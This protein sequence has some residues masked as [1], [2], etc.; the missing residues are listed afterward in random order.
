VGR[1]GEIIRPTDVDRIKIST[2]AAVATLDD[3]EL[4]EVVARGP[5]AIRERATQLRRDKQATHEDGPSTE[6]RDYLESCPVRA[7]LADPAVFD[8]Q[9]LIQ[10]RLRPVLERLGREFP[11]A[12]EEGAWGGPIVAIASTRLDRLM[13]V[14]DAGVGLTF[15]PG[16][17]SGGGWLIDIEGDGDKA[18]DSW[19][20]LLG[21]EVL[22]TL[23]WSSTRR[24]HSLMIVHE[25]RM[26]AI[27]AALGRR[28]VIK[29][30]KGVSNLP[31][32]EICCGGLYKTGTAIQIQSVVPP[33]PR[34]DGVPRQWHDI[35]TLQPVPEAFYAFL[36]ALA[37]AKAAQQA[38]Q[39]V[40]ASQGHADHDPAWDGT[41][42]IVDAERLEHAR[43]WLHKKLTAFARKV[44]SEVKGNRRTALRDHTR[45]LAGILALANN[46]KYHLLDEQDVIDRMTADDD[47]CGLEPERR[48][49]AMTWA[50]ETGKA[51]PC[52]PEEL[53][54]FEDW[55]DH[56]DEGH[57][58][59]G[60]VD[61]DLDDEAY[62]DPAY[63]AVDELD[64]DAD[65][66]P[67]RRPP[68]GDSARRGLPD[69][70]RVGPRRSPPSCGGVGHTTPRRTGPRLES[71]ARNLVLSVPASGRR[72]PET[73]QLL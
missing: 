48:N 61:D 52:W 2:I 60:A 50:L 19:A 35:E 59:L 24:G 47:E 3:A 49:D 30:K 66:L 51:E 46:Q 8:R 25:A 1:P 22:E 32:L 63:D 54:L 36:E 41:L 15:G 37:A 13:L 62:D 29:D 16:R 55:Q 69:P 14:R 23:G 56:D 65:E 10:H 11:V 73:R 70:R 4:A 67:A 5:R 26:L 43:T 71:W 44:A 40:V 68:A 42:D 9:A 72:F 17:T 57:E 7:R 33:T 45:V 58:P 27:Q 34:T 53:K 28:G 64:A 6:D 20:E 39:P 18:E 38:P 31:G 12:F 21:G